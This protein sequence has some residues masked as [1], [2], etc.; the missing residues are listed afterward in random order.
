VLRTERHQDVTRLE[1]SSWAGRR[2]GYTVSVYQ[3][4]DLVIDTGFPRV[5]RQL[6]AWCDAARPAGAIVTHWHEDHSGGAAILAARGVPLAL[7]L[8]TE[9]RLRQPPGL[10]L[11]RR[12]T[13]GSFAPL[14]TSVTPFTP[15]GVELIATPGHSVDHRVVWARET[16]TLFAGDLFLGVKVRVAHDDEDFTALI[17]SL[18]QCAALGPARMFCGH[19]GLVPSAA[20]TLGA[21]ADWLEE[22]VTVIGQRTADGWSDERIVRDVMGGEQLTGRLS[23]GHY[24]AAAFVRV[25]KRASA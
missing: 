15:N 3:V 17:A 22:M 6:A 7:H 25:A 19:R 23:R 1:L 9:R 21:K 18:R 13:W 11:Y 12:V 10:E 16:G 24:S 8:E 14:A 20:L 2:L 4:G 5:A